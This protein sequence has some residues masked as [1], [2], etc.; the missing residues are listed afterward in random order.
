[1]LQPLKPSLASN[2]CCL[3]CSQSTV[4]GSS[5]SAFGRSSPASH[6]TRRLTRFITDSAA[7]ERGRER[8]TMISSSFPLL[9]LSRLRRIIIATCY[10][11]RPTAKRGKGAFATRKAAKIGGFGC[12]EGSIGG[13]NRNSKTHSNLTICSILNPIV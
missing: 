10:G 11:L 1:M 8:E 6:L 7:G 3:R 4:M 5:S 2:I 9:S 13:R 12:G